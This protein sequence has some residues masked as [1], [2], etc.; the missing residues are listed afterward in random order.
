MDGKLSVFNLAL[1]HILLQKIHD[2]SM[3][4]VTNYV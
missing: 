1:L 3:C 4:S 2:F